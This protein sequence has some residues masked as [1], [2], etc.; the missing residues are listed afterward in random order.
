MENPP[1]VFP[2]ASG[3]QVSPKTKIRVSTFPT[4]MSCHTRMYSEKV[5]RRLALRMSRTV[6]SA[7]SGMRLLDFLIMAPRQV[8][9]EPEI[10]CYTI[11]PFCPTGEGRP[12]QP[13]SGPGWQRSPEE[14][15][16][17]LHRAFPCYRVASAD[18]VRS[19]IDSFLRC[20]DRALRD[21]VAVGAGPGARTVVLHRVGPA[22]SWTSGCRN[23]VDGGE[24]K[25]ESQGNLGQH[26]H[27][28]RMEAR[29]D[30]V[31]RFGIVCARR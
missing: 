29:G 26:G 31:G 18:F 17:R 30:F 16:E 12:P 10:L 4:S 6:L 15:D 19:P 2:A 5:S 11:R 13:R 24:R 1:S 7:P 21:L 20:A 9:D 27:S 25:R 22:G 14:D 23:G 3:S 28:P 8:N